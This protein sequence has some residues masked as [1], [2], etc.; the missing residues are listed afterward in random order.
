[1]RDRQD[2]WLQQK[3][4]AR[5][6]RDG[7]TILTRQSIITPNNGTPCPQN[8]FSLSVRKKPTGLL[9]TPLKSPTSFFFFL[10]EGRKEKAAAQKIPNSS[11]NDLTEQNWEPVLPPRGILHT[12]RVQCAN[13]KGRCLFSERC[14][15]RTEGLVL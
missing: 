3:A 9:P 14:Y 1:M 12:V 4:R 2:S 11:S 15:P 6:P 5:C 8:R 13:P 7:L 10:K